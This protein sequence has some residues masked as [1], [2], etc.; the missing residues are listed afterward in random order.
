MA[1]LINEIKL[2]INQNT[3]NIIDRY[4]FL[5]GQP[6]SVPLSTEDDNYMMKIYFN[7]ANEYLVIN[8]ETSAGELVQGDTYF[9]EYPTNLLIADA[10]IDYG[11]FFY[12]N[13]NVLR[14]Y[15]LDNSSCEWYNNNDKTYNEW[16]KML[17]NQEVY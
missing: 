13:E 10:F 1:Q 8:I 15:K 5:K 17:T 6:F 11:L 9:A 4:S 2:D 16:L 14:F 12:P 7:F 3:E